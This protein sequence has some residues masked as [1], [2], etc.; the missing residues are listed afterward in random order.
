MVRCLSFE[1]EGML[2]DT[3][4]RELLSLLMDKG[5]YQLAQ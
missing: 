1:A 3:N 4:L 2:K 5:L